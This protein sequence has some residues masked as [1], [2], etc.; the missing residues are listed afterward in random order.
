MHMKKILILTMAA[1]ALFSCGKKNGPSTRPMISWEGNSSFAEQE[2]GTALDAKVAV[3]FPEGIGTLQIKCSTVPAEIKGIISPWIGTYANKAQLLLDLQADTQVASIFK[4]KGYANPVGDGLKTATSC[5]IDFGKL[6]Q[7]LTEG[8]VLA[9]N[10]KFV[11]DLTLTDAKGTSVNRSVKFRFTPA[12][13]FPNDAPSS[14]ALEQGDTRTL[15]WKIEIPGKAEAFTIDFS[16]AKA[17]NGILSYIKKRNDNKTTIDL[18]DNANVKSAFDLDPVAKGA[19]STTLKLTNLMKNLGYEATIGSS[20][21]VT[22]RV[23]DQL[24]KESIHVL[25]LTVAQP[26]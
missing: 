17:D 9:A 22:F 7:D 14:Y 25:T 4:S 5:T 24:G 15:E 3:S 21:T 8:Q 11:F 1:L 6:T 2:I 18:I 20:T 12:P 23:V 10:S 16:G 13:M 19:T 26:Q